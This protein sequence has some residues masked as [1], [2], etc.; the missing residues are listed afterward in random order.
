MEK[1]DAM[2]EADPMSARIKEIAGRTKVVLARISAT[3]SR[4]KSGTV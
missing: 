4:R 1:I 2:N 3:V